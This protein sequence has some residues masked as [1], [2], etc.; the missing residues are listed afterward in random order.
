[1]IGDTG[2]NY[3]HDQNRMTRFQAFHSWHSIANTPRAQSQR[4]SFRLSP[5]IHSRTHEFA[6]C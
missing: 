5:T 2:H 4:S 1:M 3:N 6:L